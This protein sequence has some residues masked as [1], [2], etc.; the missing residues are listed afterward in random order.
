MK[1]KL[2]SKFAT[3]F[4][5]VDDW[6]THMT[7]LTNTYQGSDMILLEEV[8]S[9]Y[10]EELETSHE[11]V[12]EI[13]KVLYGYDQ[14]ISII[15]PNCLTICLELGEISPMPNSNMLVLPKGFGKTTFFRALE[16]FNKEYVVMLPDR[17]YESSLV[18]MC[19]RD[20]EIYRRRVWIIDDVVTTFSGMSK[21]Q[22][23][24]FQGFFTSLL[25]EG[26]YCRRYKGSN[27]EEIKDAKVSVV[28]GFAKETY[29][30]YAKE[31]FDTTFYERVVQISK[32]ITSSDIEFIEHKLYQKLTSEHSKEKLPAIK[33]PF[34]EKDVNVDV[35]SDFNAEIQTLTTLTKIRTKVSP[36]RSYNYVLKFLQG[37]ALLNGRNSV[38]KA[39]IELYK[40]VLPYHG[41]YTD[42]LEDGFRE[43]IIGE[44]FADPNKQITYAEL[45]KYAQSLGVS[46]KWINKVLRE[47]DKEFP[48]LITN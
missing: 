34:T 26:R 37:N 4:M 25:D 18:D 48:G 13:G 1:L 46:K 17:V 30:K 19:R 27:N 47:L 5:M 31:M 45:K 8:L 32:K 28:M 10:S 12:E 43:H 3:T 11:L 9:E 14:I 29:S 42:D 15:A 36:I 39:D 2:V 40:S 16:K 41:V 7:E 24:Q 38:C 6:M 21:K 44:L 33:L 20:P 22:R 23:A 35:P